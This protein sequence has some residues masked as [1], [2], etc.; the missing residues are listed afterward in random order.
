MFPYSAAQEV[1][2]TLCKPQ[3]FPNCDF[4]VVNSLPWQEITH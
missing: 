3:F 1:E 4:H 2:M